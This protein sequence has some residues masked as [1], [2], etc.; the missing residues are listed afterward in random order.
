MSRTEDNQKHRALGPR[1]GA[2]I[3]RRGEGSVHHMLLRV[4][5]EQTGELTTGLSSMKI[6]G[7]LD[8][9]LLHVAFGGR[10][11]RQ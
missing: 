7:D 8:K 6:I 5:S 3:C 2:F 9:T 11:W 4:K 10:E 1:K